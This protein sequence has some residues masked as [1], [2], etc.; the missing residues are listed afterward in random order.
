MIVRRLVAGTLVASACAVAYVLACGPFV[1]EIPTVAVVEPINL[2]A[3]AKGN[4]GVVRPRFARRYLVQAYRVL[5]GRPPLPLETL[6]PDLAAP[7]APDTHQQGP[8]AQW[9]ELARRIAGPAAVA[10]GQMKKVP[11]DSY[12]EFLNCP[13]SAFENAIRTLRA[14]AE[15]YGEKS[16]ATIAWTRAQQTVFANCVSPTPA[17]PEALPA[18]ADPLARA[19]RDYQIASAWFYTG[20]YDEAAR[21]F[22]AIAGDASSPWHVYGRY[23]VARAAIRSATLPETVTAEQHARLERLL[24]SAELELKA[25]I[26]DRSAEAVHTWARQMLDFIAARIHPV[27]RLQELSRALAT[28]NTASAATLDDYRWQMDHLVGDTMEYAYADPRRASMNEGDDLTD[29]V[30]AMQGTGDGATERAVSRWQATHTAPWLV[31]ALW[32]LPSAHPAAGALLD[33][34]A[35]IERSS[36]A[37]ATVA[38]LRVR[39]LARLDRRDEAK[40]VLA[41]SPNDTEPST[42]VEIANLLR[43]ERVMLAD[44]LD[45]FLAN[46]SR[47]A[48]LND[49]VR[50]ERAYELQRSPNTYDRPVLGDDAAIAMNDW[51]PLDRLVDAAVSPALPPRLR[52]LV[53]GM[54]LSRAIALQRAD[55]GLRVAPVLVE[56]APALRAD[57]NR[58]IN[59][60]NA[61]DRRVAGSYLLLRTPGMHVVLDTPDD[62]VSYRVKDEPTTEFDR[63]LHR[64]LW[65]DVDKRLASGKRGVGTS[66]IIG[67]LYPDRRVPAPSFITV[68]ERAAAEREMREIAA[69]GA[70]RSYLGTDALKWARDKRRDVDAAEALALTVQQW[71][72]GCGDDDKWDI[73]R[74]AFAALHRQFPQSAAAKRT[75]YWYK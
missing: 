62:D 71:H 21:R 68:E 15:R 41:A 49:S 12:Q 28:S 34:A 58:Y 66:E 36:P 44:S 35:A 70:M 18:A 13:D 22:R 8:E 20:N 54:A 37:Y 23:L 5:A 50:A 48:V 16:A 75:P 29:W 17:I 52:A 31:A 51:F 19:D 11:G 69:L 60:P 4:V 63:L 30:L 67:L 40:R 55:A 65:C 25:V 6:R 33:A 1:E 46:T 43:A 26:A 45:E 64:N 56:L 10:A 9:S 3:Y 42:D 73:A 27:E 14:R 61:D 74:Q 24:S 72:F 57:L 47:R 38:F 53:A 2:P 59:A 39:L 7:A 32:R